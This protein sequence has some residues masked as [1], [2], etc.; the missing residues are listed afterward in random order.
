[1]KITKDINILVG[2]GLFGIS[3][4]ELFNAKII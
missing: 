3:N 1:M 2:F 4:P